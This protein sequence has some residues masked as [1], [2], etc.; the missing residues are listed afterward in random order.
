MT[1]SI[2]AADPAAGQIGIA[3]ATCAFAV[4][5]RVPFIETGI[6]AV[7]TQAFTNPFYGPR[8]LAL[9][10]AGASAADAV[11]IMT[12]ADEGRA[13]RQ[14]HAMDRT[15][16]FAAYTGSGCV[17]WCG[18]VV[19][20]GFSVAG[21]MLAGPQVIDD[22]ARA[23]EQGA[24]LALAARLLAALKAGEAAGGDKRGRQSAAMLIHDGEDYALVDIRVDD[25]P[26]PLAELERLLT[27]NQARF[28]HYRKLMPSRVNPDGVVGRD[29][30]ERR[31][32]ESIA[33]ARADGGPA[34][35]G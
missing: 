18:H 7:A 13:E 22:T 30:I 4:G 12:E 34:R 19:R 33:A 3:V 32:A 8:G 14:V 29:E 20:N 24:S 6:G 5:A 11:R 27:V 16:E 23:F 9:M 26:D 10:R 17:P 21:N 31:I 35:I 28:A 15:G 25:A 2:V 1:W